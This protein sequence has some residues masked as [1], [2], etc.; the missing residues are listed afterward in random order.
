MTSISKHTVCLILALAYLGDCR[1][2]RAASPQSR[3]AL[4][5]LQL[6]TPEDLVG[7]LVP[8]RWKYRQPYPEQRHP[9]LGEWKQGQSAGEWVWRQGDRRQLGGKEIRRPPF[10]HK[11]PTGLEKKKK[12]LQ[13]YPKKKFLGPKFQKSVRPPLKVRLAPVADLR[14]TSIDRIDILRPQQQP[15]VRT[16]FI[17]SLSNTVPVKTPQPE[18]GRSTVSTA[19]TVPTITTT[20]SP[21]IEVD[22]IKIFMFRG[23]EGIGSPK[24]VK[25]NYKPNTILPV[26]D[27]KN[28]KILWSKA[29]IKPKE[30]QKPLPR[31]PSPAV[32]YTPSP[33]ST[34]IAPPFPT[35]HTTK[36]PNQETKPIVIIAQSNVAQN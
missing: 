29:E 23:D 2:P 34:D 22:G 31:A 16:P 33:I 19:P 5:G 3:R 4:T 30:V 8:T 21:P 20:S 25:L 9:V 26:A 35:R 15:G 17:P 28:K 6:P 1:R 24:Q 36:A 12:A 18:Q 11:K 10:F 7:S 32:S 14:P 27:N 13:K